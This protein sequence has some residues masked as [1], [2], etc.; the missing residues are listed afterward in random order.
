[1]IDVKETKNVKEVSKKLFKILK[2]YKLNF[3]VCSFSYKFISYFKEKYKIKSGLIINNLINKKHIENNLDF[4][5]ISYKYKNKIP[6]KETFRWTVNDTKE[7]TNENI[8]TDNPK[9]I[10]DFIKN[11]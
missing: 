9:L 5:S 8:I 4:N 10:Y 3:Y 1:M 11:S 2:K 6:N 7:V